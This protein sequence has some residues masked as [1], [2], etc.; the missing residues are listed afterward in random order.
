M[1]KEAVYIELYSSQSQN[2]DTLFRIYA[3]DKYKARI[4]YMNENSALFKKYRL[5][6]FEEKNGDFNIVYFVRK[7]GISKTNKMYNR[8]TRE[9]SIIKKGNKFY[10]CC[11]KTIT[12]LVYNH[13]TN[14]PNS[15]III[16]Y[17]VNRL[18]W[19]RYVTEHSVLRKTSFNTIY[20]KKLFSLEKALKYEYKLPLPTCKL[21]HSLKT[22]GGYDM[23]YDNLRYY[24]E[25]LDNV[26]NL[27]NTLPTYNFDLFYDTVKMA[28]TLDKMVNCSWSAKRLK[29]EHDDWAREISD[30][31]F[32][33]GNRDMYISSIYL[34]FSEYSGFKI[35]KTTKDMAHEGRVN[36]HC[37]A[38]Y[39]N[40]VEN[41]TCGIYHIGGYT[42][43]LN[44]KWVEGYC[45]LVIKQF[46]GYGNCDAPKK[47]Y[48]SV[49]KKLDKFNENCKT[50][51]ES[52]ISDGLIN[53]N[54]V[55]FNL[56]ALPF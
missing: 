1:S 42:L 38:T 53:L 49:N 19:L 35:L 13:I 45:G 50:K 18:P 56:G 43:E 17:L 11:G 7:F 12:P 41:G 54:E 51:Q 21:I 44:M 36:N 24:I 6:V 8:E 16:P 22:K 5:G 30:V 39:I 27:H 23:R 37:V 31:V 29:L 48:D 33:D 2:V 14:V 20:S 55:D 15:K 34:N 47:L 9:F 10:Y 40:K 25:Y 26:E 32:V 3:T 28:K 46:R 4:Y 52:P